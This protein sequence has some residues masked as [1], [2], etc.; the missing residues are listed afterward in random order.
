MHN[1]I[2]GGINSGD[3]KVYITNAGLY[4][5]PAKRYK[6]HEIPGRNGYLLEDTGTYENVNVTYPLCVYED[7]D[8]NLQAFLAAMRRKKGYQKIEDTFHPEYY[9]MGA[10][11]EEFEP[12]RVTNDAEMGNGS[13]DFDCLPQKYL[14]SG[15][16]QICIIDGIFTYVSNPLIE[17]AEADTEYLGAGYLT[18]PIDNVIKVHIH[19]ECEEEAQ[20]YIIS[21]DASNNATSVFFE[22]EEGSWN[23]ISPGDHDYV[24]TLPSNSVRWYVFIRASYNTKTL[25]NTYFELEYEMLAFGDERSINAILAKSVE[26]TN[27]TGFVSKP[28]IEYFVYDTS[29]IKITN[30]DDEEETEFYEL[31]IDMTRETNKHIY[32]DCDQQYAYNSNGK[33]V[34]S[35]ISIITAEHADGKSLVFPEFGSDKIKIELHENGT[36]SSRRGN[37]A[38][39]FISPKWWTV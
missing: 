37:D 1:L 3:Y 31:A 38:M 10:F 8:N 12:K 35:A 23:Y 13:I 33:N 19:N 18:K 24:V 7:C 30:I 11:L 6:K 36:A 9:R 28:L 5:S 20:S 27:P 17:D 16:E 4:R 2:Y 32:I 26:I 21:Y 22:P 39:I 29:D 25:G 34:S 15:D 14:K